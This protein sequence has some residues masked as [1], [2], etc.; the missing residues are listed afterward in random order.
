MV[1]DNRKGRPCR[2][3]AVACVG[4]LLSSWSSAAQDL[5]GVPNSADVLAVHWPASPITLA[6][7]ASQGSST[8]ILDVHKQARP[9]GAELAIVLSKPTDASY[10]IS[11]DGLR[12]TVFLSETVLDIGMVARKRDGILHWGCE[13]ATRAPGCDLFVEMEAPGALAGF[14]LTHAADGTAILRLALANGAPPPGRPMTGIAWAGGSGLDPA[15]LAF[16]TDPAQP[17]SLAQTA[18]PEAPTGQ[19]PLRQS[20][21]NPAGAQVQALNTESCTDGACASEPVTLTDGDYWANYAIGPW[22][23]LK[24]PFAMDRDSLI[25]DA[26][27]L[28]A[29]GGAYILDEDIRGDVLRERTDSSGDVFD[30]VEPLGQFWLLAGAGAAGYGTGALLGDDRLARAGLLATQAVLLT[31]LPVE[32]TKNG[33]TRARPLT[34]KGKSAWFEGGS[35]YSFLSGHTAYSFAFASAFAHEYADT[36]WV[37]FVAYGLAGAV[38]LSRIHDDKHWTSDV[39][40]SALVGW[41][42]G[43]LVTEL[44]PFGSQEALGLKPLRN[45]NAQGLSLNYKF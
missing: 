35:N 43:Q 16:A 36:G 21:G 2:V 8:R 6:S 44:D 12:V 25:M 30:L 19:P 27:A 42:V 45:G 7:L 28:A 13:A 11:A 26:V 1:S 29:F 5:P 37:P 3:A 39:V 24:R 34:G 33:F 9:G 31:A 32:A 40:L 20:A 18:L 4:M 41:G 14:R 17:V 15:L 10:R 22:E 38:G 23:M